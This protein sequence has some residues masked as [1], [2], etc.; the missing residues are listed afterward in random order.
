MSQHEQKHL[1]KDEAK[2]L[3]ADLANRQ[4]VVKKREV[5]ISFGKKPRKDAP[6]QSPHSPSSLSDDILRKRLGL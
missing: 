3:K 6:L 5:P 4:K 1:W 2:Q